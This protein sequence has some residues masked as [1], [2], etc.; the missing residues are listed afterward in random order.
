[1][2]GG[3]IAIIAVAC[4]AAVCYIA[5]ILERRSIRREQQ[6][7]EAAP[8]PPGPWT[9]QPA[10]L[11]TGEQA[12]LAALSLRY[13]HGNQDAG[14]RLADYLRIKHPGLTDIEIARMLIALHHVGRSFAR[15]DPHALAA[16]LEAIGSAALSLTELERSGITS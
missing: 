1:M 8:A 16:Y 10:V 11:E 4:L 2:N 14:I 12:S 7:N 13:A 6:R 5:T 9:T 3:Q 15:H